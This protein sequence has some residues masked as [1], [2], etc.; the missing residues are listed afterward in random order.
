MIM[1]SGPP[2]ILRQS[3]LSFATFLRH[4]LTP[5]TT[6]VIMYALGLRYVCFTL[7]Y[8]TVLLSHSV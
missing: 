1:P 3:V 6:V 4:S 8:C 5:A 7:N 2:N